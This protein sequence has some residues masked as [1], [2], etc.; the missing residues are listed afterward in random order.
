[1]Q[2]LQKRDKL[3]KECKFLRNQNA[4]LKHLLQ[5]H[6]PTNNIGVDDRKQIN[7]CDIEFYKL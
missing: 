1:M 6:L 3:Q 5:R 7:D 2:I 4:E